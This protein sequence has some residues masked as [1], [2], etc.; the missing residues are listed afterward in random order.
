MDQTRK[1]IIVHKGRTTTLEVGLGFDV[2]EDEFTSQIRVDK[3]RTSELIATWTVTFLTDGTDGELILTL[4]NLI[5]GVIA[6]AKGYMDI[7]RI[8]GGEPVNV[9]DKP[10]EVIFVDTVTV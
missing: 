9:F 1:P 6:K 2:S 5:T 3:D 4:D 8:T 7:K 10:L